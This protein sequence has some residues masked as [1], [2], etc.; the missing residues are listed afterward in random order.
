M[1]IEYRAKVSLLPIFLDQKFSQ[2]NPNFFKIL[3]TEDDKVLSKSVG[4]LHKTL[5]QCLKELYNEHIKV[6]YDWPQ[7]ELVD[8]IKK[9]KDIEIIYLCK[10]LYVPDCCKSGKLVNVNDFMS[11]FT[12][13]NYAEIISGSSPQYF[14]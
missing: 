4:A 13:Q 8:C 11:L 12:D 5:Q 10:L 6:D 14:R 2:N 3:I 9:N 1:N 7:K